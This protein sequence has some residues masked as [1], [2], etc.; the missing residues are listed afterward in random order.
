MLEHFTKESGVHY[1]EGDVKELFTLLRSML[2]IDPTR[3]PSAEEVL[4]Y[5]WFT[6]DGTA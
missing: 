6:R 3:R 5:S 4:T 1:E 2:A